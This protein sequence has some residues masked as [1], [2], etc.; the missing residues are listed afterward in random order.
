MSELHMGLIGL[1]ALGVLGVVAYNAW[2]SYRH[3]KRAGSLLSPLEKD[4]LFDMNPAPAG[5]M[6]E[7]ASAEETQEEAA[8]VGAAWESVS[9][10]SPESVPER[11]RP[12]AHE[13]D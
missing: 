6:R 4:A 7:G 10:D 12:A 9:E 8:S 5:A 2:V 1:G 11:A 3:R 13:N